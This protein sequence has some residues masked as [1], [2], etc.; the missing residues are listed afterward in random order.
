LP[1]PAFG[2]LDAAVYLFLATDWSIRPQCRL[3]ANLRFDYFS[4]AILFRSFA[5]LSGLERAWSETDK[6]TAI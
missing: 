1:A 5:T 6:P 2:G 3:S 4:A